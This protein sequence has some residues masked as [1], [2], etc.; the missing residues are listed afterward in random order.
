MHTC[1]AL[2]TSMMTPP[3]V[4]PETGQIDEHSTTASAHLQHLGEPRLDLQRHSHIRFQSMLATRHQ[5]ATHPKCAQVAVSH[6]LSACRRRSWRPHGASCSLESLILRLRR[7]THHWQFVEVYREE[8]S[9]F[10]GS[11]NFPCSP[12]TQPGRSSRWRSFSAASAFRFA[13]SA[14]GRLAGLFLNRSQICVFISHTWFN[15]E[16]EN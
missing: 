5:V 11:F 13:A 8:T 6:I 3:W 16:N 10:S 1:S 12:L 2:T 15:I 4:K 7:G 14:C 9:N